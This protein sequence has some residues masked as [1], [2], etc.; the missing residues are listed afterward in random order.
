MK[1]SKAWSPLLL[2]AGLGLAVSAHAESER[3]YAVAFGGMTSADGVSQ[4]TLDDSLVAGGFNLQESSLD[5]TD[6]G[7]GATLG[8]QVNA[9]L[10]AELSYVDL[11][12]TTYNASNSQASPGNESASFETSAQGPV[13]SFLGILPVSSRFSVYGRV[14]IALMESEGKATATIGAQSA[15]T[16]D[17]TQRS[18][19]VYGLGG[20]FDVSDRFGIRIAWDRY[21]EVGSDDIT[22]TSDIDF[23]S[24]GLRINFR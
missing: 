19:G 24:L 17:S 1:S 21:A 12:K 6:A 23:I 20:Q 11:G 13:L 10:A 14:G 15:S 22:G 4:N 18:N 3:W 2:C 16:S 9:H 8:F 7:F 5:D